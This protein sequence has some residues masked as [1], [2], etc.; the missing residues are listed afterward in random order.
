MRGRAV[1]MIAHRL[2]TVTTADKI[3]V[4]KDG[5]LVEEGRHEE[6]KAAGGLYQ[7][8]WE[9]YAQAAERKIKP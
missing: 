8:M 7:Q 9:D 1:I 2:S 4:L 5:R 6:L 3:V